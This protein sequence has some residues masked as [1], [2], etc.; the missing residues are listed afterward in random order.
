MR[1]E[2]V[3]ERNRPTLVFAPRR[4]IS[5]PSRGGGR[6]LARAMLFHDQIG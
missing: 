4:G 3:G 2:R 1:Y 6:L 5:P